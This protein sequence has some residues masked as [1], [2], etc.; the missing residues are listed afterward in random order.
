MNI[1]SKLLNHSAIAALLNL[2]RQTFRG[3]L[4]GSNSN[5]PFNE[6]EINVIKQ[7]IKKDLKL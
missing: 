2:S 5:K 3:K 7:L 4:A 1:K 6:A